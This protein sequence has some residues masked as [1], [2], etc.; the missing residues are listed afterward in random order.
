[1]GRMKEQKKLSMEVDVPN[2]NKSHFQ[3]K[4]PKKLAQWKLVWVPYPVN[5]FPYL[6]ISVNRKPNYKK[7]KGS[8]SLIKLTRWEPINTNIP[9]SIGVGIQHWVVSIGVGGVF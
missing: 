9:E 2:R 4:L 6:V 5:S 7:V 1:M 8:I 3:N